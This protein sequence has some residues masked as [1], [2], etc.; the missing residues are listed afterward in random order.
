LPA[1]F[2]QLNFAPYSFSIAI[3]YQ[4]LLKLLSTCCIEFRYCAISKK[5]LNLDNS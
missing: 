4:E 1:S 3:A 5:F 2:E